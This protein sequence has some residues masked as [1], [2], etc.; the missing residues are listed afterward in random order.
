MC[1]PGTSRYHPRNKVVSTHLF[2]TL[3]AGDPDR[4]VFRCETLKQQTQQIDEYGICLHAESSVCRSNRT[5]GLECHFRDCALQKRDG[6]AKMLSP[7]SGSLQSHFSAILIMYWLD[8]HNGQNLMGCIEHRSR[9]VSVS[10]RNPIPSCSCM[11]LFTSF[12]MTMFLCPS[13]LP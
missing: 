5:D 9:S 13:C 11:V 6:I 3:L 4:G 8:I 7:E 2:M 1:V 10:R 12:V